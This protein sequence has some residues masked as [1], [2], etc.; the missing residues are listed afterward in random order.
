MS[1]ITRTENKDHS[2]LGKKLNMQNFICDCNDFCTSF[3]MGDETYILT[4]CHCIVCPGGR[5]GLLQKRNIER[6]LTKMNSEEA[7][8]I[9]IDT[10]SDC[11]GCKLAELI[12]K[13]AIQPIIS[14]RLD[15]IQLVDELIHDSKL[16]AVIYFL[17][18]M[19]YR[20]K[21]FLLPG[22]S[23]VRV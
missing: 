21:V 5:L 23:K 7:K 10:I 4:E 9:I 13:D 17:P 6:K 16:R 12:P 2:E 11:N 15:L 18:H 22:E 8:K 3:H 20:E 14:S 1:H 19:P